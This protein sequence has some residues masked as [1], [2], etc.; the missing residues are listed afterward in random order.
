MKTKRN[1]TFMQLYR[2]WSQSN[3]EKRITLDIQWV[4]KFGVKLC[5][6]IERYDEQVNQIARMNI[7]RRINMR[8]HAVTHPDW[9]KHRTKLTKAWRSV[10]R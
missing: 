3:P 4:R 1:Q 5:K 9:P 2:Q 6:Y 7:H 8:Q 10:Q